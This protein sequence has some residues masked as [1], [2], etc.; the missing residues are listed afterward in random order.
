MSVRFAGQV[1]YVVTGM[2]NVA[3]ARVG[4]TFYQVESP[5]QPLP[6]FKPA[7]PMVCV[8]VYL[9][10]VPVLYLILVYYVHC[11]SLD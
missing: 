7:K 1:G 6:G 2:R 11:A 8:C 3:E 9:L 5:V 10:G 4:D